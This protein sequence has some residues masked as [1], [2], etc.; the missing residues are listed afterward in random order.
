MRRLTHLSKSDP[1]YKYGVGLQAL[2]LEIAL[3][4]TKIFPPLSFNTD[5]LVWTKLNTV[6]ISQFQILRVTPS[7]CFPF[8]V[9]HRLKYNRE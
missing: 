6:K 2:V 9:R 8:A 4:S 1:E 7:L 5:V 3:Y